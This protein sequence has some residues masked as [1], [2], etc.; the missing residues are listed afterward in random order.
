MSRARYLHRVAALLVAIVLLPVAVDG[1][2][3]AE[4]DR[5][6]AREP[7]EV[8]TTAGRTVRGL[9]DGFRDG[10]LHVRLATEGGEVGYSFGPDE[11]ARLQLPGAALEV[12]ALE[13]VDRAAIARAMPLLE[14]LARHRVRYLPVLDVPRQRVLWELAI[15]A[16]ATTDPHTVRAVVRAMAPIADTPDKRLTLLEAELDLALLTD[17]GDEI[18][19]LA[20]RWCAVADPA[21]RS[22]LGWRVLAALAYD[23]GDDH[24][25][26]W[27]A[28]QPVTFAGHLGMR[29]L[30]RCYAIAI[31]AAE[32]RGDRDHAHV[33]RHDM[34]L[35][36]LA[37]PVDCPVPEPG[38]R[39]ADTKTALRPTPTPPDSIDRVRKTPVPNDSP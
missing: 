33:L 36:Q 19:V 26:R 2:S 28:L 34:Q 37:W 16:R 30:D 25:A 13:Q 3:P 23:A 21:G 20:E 10:R 18:R 4:L 15:H 17:T 32:R 22:A 14:A 7:A 8:T 6:L 31:C 9:L 24:R 27:L 11:I 5:Q 29:D 12:E 1:Q 38:A 35:R 39:A